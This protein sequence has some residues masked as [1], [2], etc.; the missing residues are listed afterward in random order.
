MSEEKKYDAVM[1]I[2]GM[3]CNN[4]ERHVRQ[5]LD[6]IDG[7]HADIVDH[8]KIRPASRFPRMFQMIH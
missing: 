3:M 4:C 8:T 2:E 5:A 7:V 1:E 6:A